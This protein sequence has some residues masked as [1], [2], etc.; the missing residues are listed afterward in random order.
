MSHMW[1]E[2]GEKIPLST[3]HPP[4]SVGLLQVPGD[5]STLAHPAASPRADTEWPGSHPHPVPALASS[6]LKPELV[7]PAL[8]QP[9]PELL[10]HHTIP[11]RMF[12]EFPAGREREEVVSQHRREGSPG[13]ARRQK[14]ATVT[15]T[16][17]SSSKPGALCAPREPLPQQRWV[18]PGASPVSYPTRER[19]TLT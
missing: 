16:H 6:Q 14:T 19:R 11:Q 9:L 4:H 2:A 8:L 13:H 15:S 1:S 18:K 7:C 17:R 5:G 10:G 12:C 3:P